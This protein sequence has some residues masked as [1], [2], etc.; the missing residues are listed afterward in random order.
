MRP[1]SKPFKRGDDL[2]AGAQFGDSYCMTVSGQ[3]LDAIRATRRVLGRTPRW[4]AGLM[5]MRNLLVKPFRLKIAPGQT[6]RVS[7]GMF[8]VISES[9]AKVV[10]GLDDRHLD[11]RVLVEVE[12]LGMGRQ[13]V[14]ASTIVKT[15]NLLGRAY[16]AIV[17]PFHRIIVPAMLAQVVSE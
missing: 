11:F 10:L 8:P 16:L 9:A 13:V 3:S 6:S 2:L 15:H 14:S 5:A 1:V 7:I 17:K 4:I 12:E